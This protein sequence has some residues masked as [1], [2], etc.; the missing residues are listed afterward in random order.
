VLFIVLAP[1]LLGFFGTEFTAGAPALSVLALGQLAG[2]AAGP[3]GLTLLMTDH[4]RAAAV[5]TGVGA[6]VNVTLN[7]LLIPVYGL[8]GAAVA[9]A[10]ATA[11]T[12]AIHVLMV[13][14]RLGINSTA[15]GG[16]RTRR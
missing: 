11:L 3:A 2:A 14:R 16:L 6:V 13:R 15:L 8:M 7:A 10:F 4:E 9:S 5:G 12:G 1:F